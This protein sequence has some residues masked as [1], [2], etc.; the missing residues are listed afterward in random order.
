MVDAERFIALLNGAHKAMLNELRTLAEPHDIT[1]GEL[2]V[3]V[4]LLRDGDGVS[5]TTLRED[6]PLSKSTISKTV[7]DLTEKGLIE[8]TRSPADGRVQLIYLTPDGRALDE[9]VKEIGTT[10]TER[11]LRDFDAAEREQLATY[12]ARLQ[13]D[14]SPY[15]TR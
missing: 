9:T 1:R 3:L 13:D 14:N 4:R 11:M 10:A 2:P 12:L 7:D 5:Q 15:S 6:L 8:T